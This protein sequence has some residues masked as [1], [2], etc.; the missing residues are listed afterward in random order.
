MNLSKY[1]EWESF[2]LLLAN[3]NAK[4]HIINPFKKK[5]TKVLRVSRMLSDV[6]Q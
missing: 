5:L 6:Y 4:L 2:D 3:N 1:S